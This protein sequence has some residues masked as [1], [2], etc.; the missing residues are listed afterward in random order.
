MATN[1]QVF[2]LVLAAEFIFAIGFAFLTRYL[3]K[4]GPEGQTLWM[5][6]VGVAVVVAISGPLVGWENVRTLAACF[7]VAGL[8]MA[9][10]YLGR[11]VRE[12]R[13]A[14]RVREEGL[15]DGHAGTDRKG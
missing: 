10:E 1:W 11:V 13:E 6:V 15:D 3:A 9:I 2:G 7:G 14:R 12:E 4:N 8:P 5:V